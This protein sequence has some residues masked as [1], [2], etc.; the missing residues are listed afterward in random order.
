MRDGTLL[1]VSPGQTLDRVD[2]KEAFAE[3]AEITAYL[4]IPKSSLGRANVGELGQTEQRYF[5]TAQEMQDEGVGGNDAE[6]QFLNLNLRVLLSTSETAGYELLPIVRIK[7][8]GAEEATPEL[9]EDYIPPLLAVDAWE[10]LTI[11]IVRSIYDI[12]GEKIDVIATR[13]TERR[14]GFNS[15]Q[16]GDLEDLLILHALNEAHA[17]LRCLAFASGMHPHAIYTELCRI[18]GQLSVFDEN[19]QVEDVPL[20]DHDDLAT[21]FKWVRVQI[22]RL[23]GSRKKLGYEQRYFIGTERGMQVSIEPTWMH[24]GVAMVRRR[25]LS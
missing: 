7:R 17:V 24:S 12:V 15:P 8:S 13:A 5:A 10:S 23:L 25:E 11:G 20:Y 22:E 1:I 18:V 21:I 9:D 16:P 14:M 3:Q 19:R 6:V 4:A 2:L